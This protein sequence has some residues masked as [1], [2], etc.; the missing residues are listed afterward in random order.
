M[1]T[2]EYEKTAQKLS[3]VSLCLQILTAQLVRVAA[4]DVEKNG[5]LAS[6]L[7]RTYNFQV[8]PSA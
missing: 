3:K 5:E 7:Q 4:I 2:P 6:A 8:E 1:L